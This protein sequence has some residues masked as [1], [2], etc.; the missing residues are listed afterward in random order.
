VLAVGEDRL[1]VAKAEGRPATAEG[2]VLRY[3]VVEGVP[4]L[5][6]ASAASRLGAALR[7]VRI[8]RGLS[9]SEIARLAGVSP[10]AISQAERGQR[11]LSLETLLHLTGKLNITIDELLRGQVAPGYRLARRHD[12]HRRGEG[13]VLALFDDP[14]A[15][16]RSYLVRLGPRA[17]VSAPS[18]HKGV[19]LV[20]VASGLVQVV[21]TSGRPVLRSGE[22]LLAEQSGV[23]A[24]RNLGDT[25]AMAF[26]VLR[27]KSGDGV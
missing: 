18:A 22:T 11:G 19:E 17:S 8:N 5:S 13:R 1:R 3:R 9:Q 15:G 24:W 26:W 21:L 23:Q 25:E 7:A 4:E 10:S 20:A 6:A 12:P 14:G 16:L 2:N 27:D